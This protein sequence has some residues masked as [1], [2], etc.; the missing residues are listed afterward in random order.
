LHKITQEINERIG[1]DR[2]EALKTFNMELQQAD[3]IIGHNISFDKRL[4]MVECIRNKVQQHFNY[5]GNKKYE[6][7][8][9]KNTVDLCKIEKIGKEGDTYFKYP[10]L[11]E[12]YF[13][14]F[15]EVPKNV[16]N[17]FMDVLFCLRCYY[18]ITYNMDLFEADGVI[19]TMCEK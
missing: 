3:I 5:R 17:S 10:T 15:N 12:L 9:M 18:K 2:R 16:H 19:K 7:C 1:V 14:L 6:Y 13:H 11:S 8:T 4:I